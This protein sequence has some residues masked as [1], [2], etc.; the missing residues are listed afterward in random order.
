MEFTKDTTELIFPIKTTVETRPGTHKNIF[1]RI[2]YTENGEPVTHSRI[3]GT[4]LRVDKPIPPKKDAP[5]KPAPVAKAPE[6]KKPEEPM[7][8]RLTRLQ[9]LRLDAKKKAEAEAGGGA[10]E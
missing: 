2:V 6:P 9:Q 4:E 10:E 3:G 8:V 5:P 1:L 7:K